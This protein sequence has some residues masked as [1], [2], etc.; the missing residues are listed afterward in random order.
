MTYHG[1]SVSLYRPTDRETDRETETETERLTDRRTVR[2]LERQ[3]AQKHNT[4]GGH[5]KR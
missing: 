4:L 1:I 3:I 5:I 2:W